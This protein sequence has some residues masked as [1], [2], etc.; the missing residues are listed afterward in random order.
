M[1]LK[2][3]N[4]KTHQIDEI[5]VPDVACTVKKVMEWLKADIEL[6][7]P[8]YGYFRIVVDPGQQKDTVTLVAGIGKDQIVH[9]VNVK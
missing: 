5:E 2:C 1:I 6:K 9:L 7:H 4:Y 8:E 3:F